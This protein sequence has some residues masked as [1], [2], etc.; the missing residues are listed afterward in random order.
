MSFKEDPSLEAKNDLSELGVGC[1]KDLGVASRL[2]IRNS[3]VREVCE[4]CSVRLTHAEP[5]QD[6]QGVCGN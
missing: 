4:C 5:E 3:A 2:I 6:M 1:I